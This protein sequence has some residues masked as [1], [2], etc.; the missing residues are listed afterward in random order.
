MK[1]GTSDKNNGSGQAS[2]GRK[3]TLSSQ[4][5]LEIL[6]QEHC[7]GLEELDKIT[8]AID[9][10]HQNGFSAGAF[11][12]IALS[13]RYLG[14]E[15]RK[16]YEKEERHLFPLL[17]K[18]LFESPNEIRYERREMWQSFNELINTIRDVEDGRFHGSAIR[19]LL[20]CAQQVVE[21]F[22]THIHRENDIILP[23]VKRLLTS[24]EYVQFGKE[25][26]SIAYL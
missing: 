22:R 21:H 3:E 2:P 13:V 17:D 1:L 10:I 24:D 20:Q 8:V 14:S 15:M 18:H 5:P 6:R 26:Q 12:Q 19:D 23:M 11:E 16:H 7:R 25:I 9:S 4:D